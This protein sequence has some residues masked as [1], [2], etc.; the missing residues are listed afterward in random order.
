[1]E[2]LVREFR[3]LYQ[4]SPKRE[5]DQFFATEET[6][7]KKAQIMKDKGSLDGKDILIIGDDDLVS[8]ACFVVGL[9]K[10]VTVLEIDKDLSH[11]ISNMAR[12]LKLPLVV[13]N[14]DVR[15]GNLLPGQKFQTIAFDPPYTPPGASLFL[16]RSLG[17]ISPAHEESRI[18]M[19]FGS[20]PK[21]TD[22]ILKI[23]EI[24]SS[25]S[26]VV[27]EK[28]ANF[29]LYRGA[30]GVN[31]TSSMYVLKPTAIS[32]V[33]SVSYD[34]EKIYTHNVYPVI[35][36][37]HIEHYSMMFFGVPFKTATTRRDLETAIINSCSA[38]DI[39]WVGKSF[40]KFF[41]GGLTL[42]FVLEKSNL[43][44]HSWPE[45]SMVHLDLL[46][47][48]KLKDIDNMP[49]IFAKNLKTK[50]FQFRRLE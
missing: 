44:V 33:G 24:I 32:E 38:L 14:A 25:F 35:K 6:T 20:G 42:N 1:M 17:Y 13:Y 22:K 43:C 41:G 11:A 30:S 5:F 49:F 18:F 37:P 28:F 4:I 29:N 50:N 10:S 21:N 2:N 34:L 27:E 15:S 8:L 26:L 48:T 12:R 47:C 9:P 19:C 46:V 39:K 40:K 7:Y 3:G 36:L 31:N 45:L 16:K 23:Q